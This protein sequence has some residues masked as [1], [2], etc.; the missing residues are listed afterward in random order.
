MTH[1]K[2]LLGKTVSL[3]SKAGV[4]NLLQLRQRSILYGGEV[5]ISQFYLHHNF[6]L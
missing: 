3:S 6:N 2:R 1:H 5:I 4:H